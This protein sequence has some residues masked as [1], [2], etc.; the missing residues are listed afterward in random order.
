MVY[1]ISSQPK[2]IYIIYFIKNGRNKMINA[3]NSDNDL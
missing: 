2:K 1:Y 3:T